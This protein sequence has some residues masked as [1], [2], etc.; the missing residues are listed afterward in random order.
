MAQ[1]FAR[2]HAL[3][4]ALSALT[5]FPLF[6][7]PAPPAEDLV[8]A[9]DQA[10]LR[11]EYA[12]A[13]KQATT[14]I[15]QLQSAP[16]RPELG[17]AEN[18][19]GVAL[20]YQGDYAA[21]RPHFERAI[22]LAE[23]IADRNA[24]LRRRNNLGNVDFYLGRYVEAYRNYQTALQRLVGAEQQ[25][26]YTAA[27]QMT[28]TNLA[29]LHQQLGQHR[30]ALDIYR[31]IRAM[32]Q[33]M[34]PNVEAQMLTNLAIV[35][36]RLGDP[37]KALDTYREARRL[38]ASDPHAAAALYTLHNIGVVLALDFEDLPGALHTFEEAAAIASKS[39]SKRELTLEHLF[40]GET[41]LR[42]RRPEAAAKHFSAAL[43]I[44]TALQLV[45]ERWTA[46]Y[47]LGRLQAAA[48]HPDLGRK[49]F[50]AAIAIIESARTKL[51]NSSLKAEFLA[52]KHDVYDAWIGATLDSP[53]PSPG[54][55]LRR[56]EEGRARILKDLLPI[57]RQAVDLPALQR[58][59]DGQTCVLAYWMAG[60]RLA[61]VW[62]TRDA[63]GI[64]D[65][66]V[67]AQDLSRL[68][69]LARALTQKD[70]TAWVS[71]ADTVSPLLIDDAIPLR[72]KL[73]IVPDGPLHPIPFEVLRAPGG[74]R[75]IESAAI[76]YLPSTHFLTSAQTL[77]RRWPWQLSVIAFG[78]P[79]PGVSNGA[80]PFDGAGP[81]L[82]ESAEEARQ[83]AASLPGRAVIHTG[84]DNR[85]S[86]LFQS[87]TARA[88]VLHFATHAVVD[89]SDS[90]RSRLVFSP[91]AGDATSQYLFSLEIADLPLSRVELVT[92]AA[93]ESELGRYVR[94]EGVGNFGRAFLA[95]GAAATVTSLWRVSD[96]AS[97]LLMG[98]FYRGLA[99]GLTKAEALRQAKLTILHAGGAHAHPYFWAPYLVSGDAQTPLSPTI[100]WWPFPVTALLLAALVFAVKKLF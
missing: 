95:A 68:T 3:E 15:G 74:Q 81:R 37:Q 54:A 76:S 63:A 87:E 60:Q 20:L 59:L 88:R 51:G 46:L 30:Q 2:R 96:R 12:A 34:K 67:S 66:P 35:Y 45:D 11:G 73:V 6:A 93:C 39:G 61:V 38:L 58:R 16:R 98:H 8:R 23:A 79:I 83:V 31:E 41:L 28:L 55:I 13:A 71:L 53:H 21:A 89:T 40:L 49:Y 56:I 75:L 97:S 48:G 84:A 9:A 82:P 32:P 94:G 36:R 19:L 91:V 72:Q 90:R 24:E 17:M 77:P 47:G 44:A 18:I 43:E 57:E 26:W 64:L 52:E 78:D 86:Y 27:R 4:I 14:A 1:K 69:D 85:K 33:R 92:L 80:S 29:V 25:P 5:L 62:F 65:R 22:T 42:M 70:S 50:D 7:Q 99:N 10:L 100:P